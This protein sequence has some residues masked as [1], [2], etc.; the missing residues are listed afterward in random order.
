[1][2]EYGILA[3]PIGFLAI[4]DLHME[5]TYNAH[6]GLRVSGY[7][8]DEEEERNLELLSKTVW[9]TIKDILRNCDRVFFADGK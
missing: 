6:G 1:M 9:E 3:E 7:I 5:L 4:L 2:R 8:S